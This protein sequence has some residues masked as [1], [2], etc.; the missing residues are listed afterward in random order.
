[1]VCYLR[2]QLVTPSRRSADVSAFMTMWNREEFWHG[3]ALAHILGLHGISVT[4]DHLKARRIKLGWRDR[5]VPVRQ[6]VLGNV[7]GKDFIA[8]H[9]V[10]GA[11]NE[12]SAGAA[13]KRLAALEPHP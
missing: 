12:W 11:V 2:D 7:A 9:M 4:Y 6:S 1:T 10:W 13:Y 3:E 5:M 8:V